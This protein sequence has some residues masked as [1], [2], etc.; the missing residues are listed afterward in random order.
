MRKVFTV[1]VHGE[2]L[3]QRIIQEDGTGKDTLTFVLSVNL[4]RRHLGES[5][6]MVVAARIENMQV[7]D[8]QHKKEGAQIC[9]TSQTNAAEK[10]NVSRRSV[11]SGVKARAKAEP[12][13]IHAVEQ[14]KM[15]VSH[16]AKVF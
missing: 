10:L 15:S 1:K 16:A 12:D 8:N 14:G 7:G 9:A 3:A 2:C 13:I 4:H 5:Q 11:Q 6:K